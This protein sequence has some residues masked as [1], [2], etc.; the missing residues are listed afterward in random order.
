[1]NYFRRLIRLVVMIAMLVATL[2]SAQVSAQR[3]PDNE[4]VYDSELTGLEI[5]YTDDWEL[6]DAEVLSGDEGE[7][8]FL[9]S[10]AGVL[11]IGFGLTDDVENSVTSTI[12]DVDGAEIIDQGSDDD[13]AWGLAGV[14]ESIE[15][16]SYVYVEA[17]NGF[18]D[19]YQLV[20]MLMAEDDIIDQ[21]DLVQETVSIDG[22]FVFVEHEAD[23]LE[24]LIEDGS[25]QSGRIDDDST[26]EDEGN[27]TETGGTGRDTG[28][29]TGAGEDENSYQFE[30]E[31]VE[32][33]VSGAVTIDDVQVQDGSYEQILLVGSGSIG[34]VSLI[35]NALDAE[36]TLEGF[37]S[38]FVSEMEDAEEIDSGVDN[39]VAWTLYS[40]STG[41][42]ELYVYATVDANRFDDS[43][44]LE[45]I[46]APTF[47]FEDEFVDFQDSVEVDGDGMFL[48]SDIDDLMDIIDGF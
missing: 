22:G 35:D 8:I 44:Y 15:S 9:E 3:L 24:V 38:G 28:T 18:V 29:D 20:A 4:G 26:P 33:A 30:M 12:S 34:A 32:V 43:H 5:T 10:S 37:M 11:M 40:A 31:N 21:F 39:G 46:A 6:A 13:F 19:D 45:L 17:E 41:G 1:M 23:E 7:L 47:T 14:E 27:L 36:G 48:E 16:M 42:S 2:G 25:L